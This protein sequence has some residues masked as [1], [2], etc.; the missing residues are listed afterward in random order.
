MILGFLYL[1]SALHG[2]RLHM[3]I[4][5]HHQVSTAPTTA[6]LWMKGRNHWSTFSELHK[7]LL[8]KIYHLHR[9]LIANHSVIWH[10]TE[11]KRI[12]NKEKRAIYYILIKGWGDICL[13]WN[14]MHWFTF[15]WPSNGLCFCL[16]EM[17]HPITS[18]SLSCSWQ[19]WVCICSLHLSSLVCEIHCSQ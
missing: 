2:L 17:V 5:P 16:A 18:R 19:M 8:A 6:F 14:S 15:M 3:S 11:Q 7:Y 12:L 9:K 4:T 10:I 1:S 13:L